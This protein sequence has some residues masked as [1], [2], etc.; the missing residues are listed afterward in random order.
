MPL[1]DSSL[2]D[3]LTNLNDPTNDEFVFVG[4]QFFLIDC[5][6]VWRNHRQLRPML[7]YVYCWLIN[8]SGISK[9]KIK[10]I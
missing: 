8:R 7:L 2:F 4:F 9:R 1:P 10:S 3:F 5:A 6:L